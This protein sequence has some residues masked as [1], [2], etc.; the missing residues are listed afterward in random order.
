MSQNVQ[1][2]FYWGGL[3][4][5]SLSVVLCFLVN[6]KSLCVF[7][8][9]PFSQLP[10]FVTVPIVLH[11]PDSG[12][13][14]PF[15]LILAIFPS[16]AVQQLSVWMVKHQFRINIHHSTQNSFNSFKTTGVIIYILSVQWRLNYLES[17]GSCVITKMI[18]MAI[19]RCVI[20]S[21]WFNYFFP[22]AIEI[23]ADRRY[24]QNKFLRTFHISNSDRIQR[25]CIRTLKTQKKNQLNKE[26]EEMNTIKQERCLGCGNVQ[27]VVE[28]R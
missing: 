20:A 25:Q 13:L 7:A 1:L 14:S 28:A 26:I 8:P 11:C 3:C 17:A 5:T 18:I 24:G 23:L 15:P 27:V 16:C 10:V 21:Q 2:F 4:S 12:L 6:V 22:C 19:P 9:F